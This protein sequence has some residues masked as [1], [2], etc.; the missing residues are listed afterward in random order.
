VKALTIAAIWIAHLLSL[1]VAV[2][3]IR[4][5]DVAVIV[6][7]YAYMLEY[8]LRLATIPMLYHV[9]AAARFVTRRPHH[10]Q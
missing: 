5:G 9:P 4:T 1:A 7:L 2:Y 6:L 3:I 8:V 10:N